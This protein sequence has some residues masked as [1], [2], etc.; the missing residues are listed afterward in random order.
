MNKV[1]LRGKLYLVNADRVTKLSNK[2]FIE[3]I[4]ITGEGSK[5]L[6]EYHQI[7]IARLHA[8][9]TLANIRANNDD[10]TEV[11]LE[12]RLTTQNG[13]SIVQCAKIDFLVNNATAREAKAI[14]RQLKRGDS[15][16]EAS[17][18]ETAVF[19]VQLL[20]ALP[21]QLSVSLV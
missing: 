5:Y 7:L 17:F 16:L 10:P 3:C 4:L 12:G 18:R 1:H 14:L 13:N 11:C 21:Q 9:Q 6:L 20:N 8:I 15:F 19:H 2:P